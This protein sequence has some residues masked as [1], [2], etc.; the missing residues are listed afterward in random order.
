MDDL[1]QQ[2]KKRDAILLGGRHMSSFVSFPW[3]SRLNYVVDTFC[4]A[5]RQT[6]ALKLGTYA[7]SGVLDTKEEITTQ[8]SSLN[9]GTIVSGLPGSGKTRE[10]M[11]IIDQAIKQECGAKVAIISPTDEWD[12]FAAEHKMH[13]IRLGRDDVPINFFSSP[14]CKNAEKFY[15]DLAILISAASNSG[16]YQNPMEKCL[17]NAFKRASMANDRNPTA[18]YDQ[19]EESIIRFHGRVT[20]AGVK[21]TKHGENIKAALENLRLI[22]SNQQ[23]SV[24]R[25][26][27]FADLIKGGAVFSLSG[28]SN[29]A[30]PYFYALLLNQMYSIADAFDSLG[31]NELRLLMCV[32]EAQT[33]FGAEKDSAATNDL[34]ERIQDF[35]KRGVGLVLI[36]HSITDISSDIRR[37]CQN[38]VYLKQAPDIA[39][40]A[41]KDLVFTYAEQDVVVSKLKH[42]NSR[43]GA[44][45]FV[46]KY[47][48]EKL[49][50]DS[51]FMKTLDYLPKINSVKGSYEIE[52]LKVKSE[53]EIKML[54]NIE[55]R[56][57]ESARKV[58]ELTLFFIGEKACS[59]PIIDNSCTITSILS[60]RQYTITL[61]SEGNRALGS[62]K[63]IA[64]RKLRLLLSDAGLAVSNA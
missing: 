35:R 17:L 3:V 15:E 63:V 48:D 53:S 61:V 58:A 24:T 45:S 30:K 50:G 12:S 55:D 39:A 31:D 8:W 14:D 26:V 10:V 20:K 25:G 9:L 16:P 32:E 13:L 60:G 43:I 62:C 57:K 4:A 33:I 28:V 34:I 22:L 41:A 52:K 6:G 38:K 5:D 23:Y 40:I 21:Y 44:V 42:L 49:S 46:T 56:R 1:M 51:V 2:L 7:R 59:N 37:M 36:T 19:I 47:G 64:C 29:N 11:S 27:S 18:I 54:V